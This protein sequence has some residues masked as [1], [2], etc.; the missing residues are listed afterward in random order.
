MARAGIIKLL[1]PNAMAD[2]KTELDIVME[3]IGW[4]IDLNNKSVT[5]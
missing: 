3:A 5:M 1:G 4:R 2:E